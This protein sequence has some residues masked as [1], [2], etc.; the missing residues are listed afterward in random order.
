MDPVIS[1]ILIGIGAIALIVLISIL[2]AKK[3]KKEVEM[4]DQM[5]PEGSLSS[6]DMKIAVDRVRRT[7]KEREKRN[8]EKQKIHR[9]RPK[10]GTL[11]P[12]EDKEFISS[13]S[14]HEKRISNET[15]VDTEPDPLT[16]VTSEKSGLFA[17]SSDKNK[18]MDKQESESSDTLEQTDDV[19]TE[20]SKHRRLYKKS[21]LKPD[22]KEETMIRKE[23]LLTQIKTDQDS[24]TSMDEET[25]NVSIEDEDSEDTNPSLSRSNKQK[26]PRKW[27]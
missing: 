27:F 7:T 21:L 13:A 16:E 18:T 8:K 3:R 12:D 23:S 14:F 9:E 1:G 25:A 17:R 15:T 19:D 22:R 10:E 6:E 2:V 26:T 4:L 5:F 24:D 20:A 11:L